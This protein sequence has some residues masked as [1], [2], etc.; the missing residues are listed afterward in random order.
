MTTPTFWSWWKGRECCLWSGERRG[1]EISSLESWLKELNCLGCKRKQ[2]SAR[3]PVEG[4]EWSLTRVLLVALCS[5][6]G[7]GLQ[8]RL[9]TARWQ[10]RVSKAGSPTREPSWE[11]ENRPES[12]G[13]GWGEE[14]SWRPPPPQGQGRRDQKGS[15]SAS[16]PRGHLGHATVLRGLTGRAKTKP[17][18]RSRPRGWAWPAPSRLPTQALVGVSE[19]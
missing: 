15:Q 14:K 5:P 11:R 16:R 3:W 13:G 12:S 9:G 7:L 1:E 19:C 10:P 4:L 8:R 6:P 18:K 2:V 17:L